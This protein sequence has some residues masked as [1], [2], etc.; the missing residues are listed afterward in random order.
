MWWLF[1][2]PS[3]VWAQANPDKDLDLQAVED[4]S[5]LLPETS[6][7]IETT[8][9]PAWEKAHRKFKTP[10]R[11]V[12]MESILKS[13]TETVFLA[14]KVK[15]I[16][17]SDQQKLH[18]YKSMNVKVYRLPDELGFKYLVGTDQK[19][20]FKIHLDNITII[21]EELVLYEPPHRYTPA[22]AILLR[23]YDRKLN[24]LPEAS[25]YAGLVKGDFMKDLFNDASAG[26]GFSQQYGA[27]LFTQWKLPIIVG[28]SLHY[29][30]TVYNLTD[31]EKIHFSAFSF[32]PQFKSQDFHLGEIPLRVQAQFRFSPFATAKSQS[33]DNDRDFE[34]NSTDFLTSLEYPTKNSFGSFVL[35]LFFQS[36]WLNLKNQ[37]KFIDVNA[38]N[39]TNKTFGLSLSQVFE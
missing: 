35:G 24:L 8:L 16:R 15:I 25:F 11:K 17:L 5:Q 21:K 4:L 6:E 3:L 32:G 31:G 2:L 26:S 36:Q 22:P 12:N 20:K 30:N 28:A 14:E 7:S 39:A 33:T 1:L 38:T 18:L 9:D 13:G 19:V 34:F 10:V 27:Q 37:S 29:E 23:E